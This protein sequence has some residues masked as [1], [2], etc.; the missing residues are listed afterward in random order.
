LCK[1]GLLVAF[2]VLLLVFLKFIAFVLATALILSLSTIVIKV[3]EHT[4]ELRMNLLIGIKHLEV[5]PVRFIA[6]LL[7]PL[8]R[9]TQGSDGNGF[10]H[11]IILSYQFTEVITRHHHQPEFQGENLF[12]VDVVRL[13]VRCFCCQV[14]DKL[15]IVELWSRGVQTELCAELV[16]LGALLWL[17]LEA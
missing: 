1:G 12:I 11:V 16:Q 10:G 6:K 8:N 7:K 3:L 9:E 13:L 4:L 17:V 14:E 15:V 2:L 5:L